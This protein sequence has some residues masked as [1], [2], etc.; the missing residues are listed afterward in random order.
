[1]SR[2]Y[3]QVVFSVMLLLVNSDQSVA[4]SERRGVV[5][6][7]PQASPG[8]TLIAPFGGQKTYLIDLDGKP[9]HSWTTNR[10]PSQ[11]AYLLE[12]GSLLR[13]TKIA[14][15]TFNVQEDR[16]A[17]FKSLTGTVT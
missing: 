9:V 15:D 10:R 12:D 17:A 14:N 1:M 16:R 4:Q 8:Y 11:A 6:K 5:L 13:T 3:L 2:Q 7:T